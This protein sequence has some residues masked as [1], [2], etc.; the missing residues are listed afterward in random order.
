MA[1]HGFQG[2][3]DMRVIESFRKDEYEYRP[4]NAALIAGA[5]P[6]EASVGG[7]RSRFRTGSLGFAGYNRLKMR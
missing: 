2:R 6:R 4:T 5:T 1:M 7:G 3:C